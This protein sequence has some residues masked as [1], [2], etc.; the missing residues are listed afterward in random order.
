M[1]AFP[2]VGQHRAMERAVQRLGQTKSTDS[3]TF[4]GKRVLQSDVDKRLDRQQEGERQ[5]QRTGEPHRECVLAKQAAQWRH[6]T[7]LSFRS[8]VLGSD[9]SKGVRNLCWKF[10]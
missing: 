2:I 3:D 9:W 10:W 8:Y 5:N 4:L 6:A 1:K 7:F